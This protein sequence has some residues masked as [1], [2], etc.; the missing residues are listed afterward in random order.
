MTVKIEVGSGSSVLRCEARAIG[1]GVVY[2]S[3]AAM[4][5]GVDYRVSGWWYT[6]AAAEK[7]KRDELTDHRSFSCRETSVDE[8][9]AERMA[10]LRADTENDGHAYFSQTYPFAVR[11]GE[12]YLLCSAPEFRDYRR[13]G[14]PSDAARRALAKLLNEL[15]ATVHDPALLFASAL[16]AHRS[17][18]EHEDRKRAAANAVGNVRKSLGALFAALKQ[19]GEMVDAGTVPAEDEEMIASLNAALHGFEAAATREEDDR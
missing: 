17:E 14:V 3:I 7:L 8:Q 10:K 5:R 6:A 16:A 18:V 9:V 19:A 2:A 13:N 11:H 4:I 1:G 12:N 15:T